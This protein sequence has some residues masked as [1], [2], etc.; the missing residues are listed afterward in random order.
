M[1]RLL[2]LALVIGSA[3]LAWGTGLHE[4]VE[5]ET[6]RELVHGA[7]VWGPVLFI[8]LFGLEGLGVPGV[9]FM[10]AAVAIW[11]PTLAFLYNFLGAQMAGLVGFG[12]AR[13]MGRDWV[14]DRLPDNV[15]RFESRIE[16]RGLATVILVRLVFFLAPPAHWLLG[17]S[18]VRF[19]DYLLGTAIGMLPWLIAVSY[20]GSHAFRW[21]ADQ[22]RELWM[23]LAGVFVVSAGGWRILQRR[24]ID[25]SQPNPL[26]SRLAHSA[27]RKTP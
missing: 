19:R 2:L 23:I 8:A 10:V 22:P 6:I 5:M 13:W 24:R 27:E 21:L 25:H 18:P 14:A 9:V 7:G 16:E 15:R 3:V 11:P 17:L 1:T 4:K 12:F 26:P 20:G